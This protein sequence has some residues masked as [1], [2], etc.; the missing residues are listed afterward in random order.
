MDLPPEMNGFFRDNVNCSPNIKMQW[1]ASVWEERDQII[2]NQGLS[3]WK[4]DLIA[5]SFLMRDKVRRTRK[6]DEDF[7]ALVD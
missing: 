3:T 6:L 2:R 1:L 4:K 7:A 5:S